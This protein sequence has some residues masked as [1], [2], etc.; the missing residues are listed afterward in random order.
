M[1][2]D[3]YERLAPPPVFHQGKG[4][5][6]ARI[7][8]EAAHANRPKP[9]RPPHDASK[10]KR[11]LVTLL[12]SLDFT[13]ERICSFLDIDINT[14]RKYYE[15]EI[16]HGKTMLD[17]Q[18][19]SALFVNIQAKKEKSVIYYLASRVP[20]FM[21]DPSALYSGIATPPTTAPNQIEANPQTLQEAEALYESMRK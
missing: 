14:L 3:D 7:A 11:A 15:R 4:K 18:A 8:E 5:S 1:T 17:V 9:G 13:K 21:Q 12:A 16:E 10:D 20:G 6:Y 2:G 19:L